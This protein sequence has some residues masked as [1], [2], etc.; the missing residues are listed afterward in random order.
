MAA[1]FAF[2][3]LMG[4]LEIAGVASMMPLADLLIH[5]QNQSARPVF[6]CLGLMIVINLLGMLFNWYSYRVI[7]QHAFTLS[8]RLLAYYLQKPFIAFLADDGPAI[9]NR[10]LVT[11][12]QYS[13]VFLTASVNVFSRLI[14]A[15]AVIA[16]LIYL[17]P[18]M[19][20]SLMAFM[21]VSYVL[22]SKIIGRLSLKSGQQRT[23]S[24]NLKFKLIEDLVLGFK[25]IKIG[26]GEKVVMRQ[27][28]KE[29]RLEFA[30]VAN[31]YFLATIP[32]NVLEMVGFLAVF[33]SF[34]VIHYFSKNPA[35]S[36]AILAAYGMAGLRLLPISN[37]VF[38][39]IAQMRGAKPYFD[40]FANEVSLYPADYTKMFG[41]QL[42][43][44]SP[45]STSVRLENVSFRYPARFEHAVSNVSMDIKKNSVV[46]LAGATGA[47][48]STIAEIACGLLPPSEGIVT[49]DGQELTILPGSSWLSQV[50]YVPQQVHIFADTVLQNISC[51]GKGA[52]DLERVM[53]AAK[54]VGL[55]DFVMGE[56]PQGYNTI[57]GRGRT[58]LSGGQKQRLGFARAIY[59]EP[60]F[61][62]LD[63]PTSALDGILEHQ[64]LASI[65]HMSQSSPILLIGHRAASLRICDQIYFMESGLIKSNGTFEELYALEPRFKIMMD[66]QSNNS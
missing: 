64:I 22:V 38:Q 7:N 21:A 33:T 16:F 19:G 36:I 55:H 6:I 26:Q 15:A 39:G 52:P 59:R 3:T 8:C 63:E 28:E 37:Q 11:V 44:S 60:R 32:R 49:V 56:L 58:L 65:K 1:L 48:K 12:K 40:S 27:F 23:S 14:V 42:E 47:G 2:A 51:F 9:G 5:P 4:F 30:A 54:T 43:M 50:G 62:L 35:D 18:P 41:E 57:L 17:S 46:G 31:G 10:L 61:L 25:E 45:A 13:M 20:F 29:S 34:L 66:L 53:E 24:E